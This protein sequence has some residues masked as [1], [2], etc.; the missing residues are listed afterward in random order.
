MRNPSWSRDELI[1]ALEFYF[2][3]APSIPGKKSKQIKELSNLL[4]QLMS[5]LGG[6]GSPTFRNP[7]GVY[8]KL[9]NFRRFDPNY[10]GVG[11]QRGNKD[12]EV[13]WKLFFSNRSEL[14]KVTESILS[15]VVADDPIPPRES[16]TDEQ[17]EGE[18]GQVL[19]RMHH[20]RERNT[21]LVKDKK[22]RIL[23][24]T[25]ELR[26][27]ICDFDFSIVYGDH[28]NGFIECH[29]TKPLS[30]LES[31]QKTSLSDL[32]LVCSNCHRM[33][34]RKRP[35]L[36]MKQLRQLVTSQ[37]RTRY[38]HKTRKITQQI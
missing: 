13:V 38:P 1:I 26:C 25:G 28:G 11:L 33:I 5:K 37:K 19:S 29:H 22:Y 18:E 23:R 27:E 15:L 24:D 2:R 17:E 20:Y 10:Q 12:E 7:N 30:E 36:S 34:H 21:K 9:M 8:M 16:M 6:E 32:C 31:G 35:W 14:K 4:N 3:Y